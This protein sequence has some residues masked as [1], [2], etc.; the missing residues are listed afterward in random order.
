MKIYRFKQ[1]PS[2]NDVAKEIALQ[3][4]RDFVVVSDEQTKGKGRMGRE[5]KSPPGGLYFS[6]VTEKN[7]H[8]PLIVGVSVAS[9]LKD[10]GLS[11]VLKWPNDVMIGNK[12]ISGILI[13]CLDDFAVVGVGVNISKTPMETAT[14]IKD[15]T[16]KNV[17]KDAVL[18]SILKNFE[19]NKKKTVLDEYKKLCSTIGRKVKIKTLNKV[20]KGKAV[21]VDEHGKLVLESGERIVSG[22]VIH[23]R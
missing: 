6:I 10:F 15:E 21:D 7:P 1:V 9:A 11:P 17:S 23:L 13:E 12:K 8:L 22:D 18:K 16:G 5:W 14:S 3:G 19:K 2:T 20:I 4:E